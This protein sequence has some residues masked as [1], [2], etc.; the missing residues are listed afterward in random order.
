MGG[1]FGCGGAVHEEEEVGDGVERIV[2]LVGDGGGEAAGDGKFLIGEQ[3]L[4]G[5]AGDGDIAKDE[6]EADDGG[7]LVADGG[8]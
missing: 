3:G 5:F 4:L 2:D 6:D 7:V 8:E 1:F